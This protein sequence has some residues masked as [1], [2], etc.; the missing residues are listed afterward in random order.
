MFKMVYRLLKERGA[1]PGL[2]LA[3]LVGLSCVPGR[4]G[5]QGGAAQE[6]TPALEAQVAY[7]SG[8]EALRASHAG[9]A[10][11][12]FQK[13][14]TLDPTFA[15]PHFATADTWFPWRPDQAIA[16]TVRGWGAE[17]RTFRGQ[18][19]FV[20]NGAILLLMILAG[21]LTGAGAL[22]AFRALAYFHHPIFELARTRLPALAAGLAA[23]IVVTQPLLWGLGFY[24]TLVLALGLTWALQ[25]AGERRVT[26][27]AVAMGLAIPLALSGLG[28]MSAP[29][30]PDSSAYLLSAASE[31]PGQP[32]LGESL[33]R[34]LATG[35]GDPATHLARGLVA[36][37]VHDWPRAETEYRKGLELRGDEAHFRTNLG[38]ALHQQGRFDEAEA[39][40]VKAIEKNAK[41][42]APH[43]NLAQLSARRLQFDRVD[44]EMKIASRLDFEGVRAVTGLE[45]KDH[46]RL[47]SID[48]PAA[49]LWKATLNATGRPPLGFPKALGLFFGG[50]VVYLPWLT[51]GLFAF[52]FLVG[53]R[54]HRFLPTYACA[55]CGSVVCRKCLRRVR[56]RA[57]CVDCGE[58]ILSLNTSEFTRMLLERRLR[59]TTWFRE[60]M[61]VALQVVVPGWAAVRRGRPVTGLLL[62]SLFMVIIMPVFLR[63]GAVSPVPALPDHNSISVWLGLGLGLAFLYAVSVAVFRWLPDPDAALLEGEEES[64]S[65]RDTKPSFGRA[66]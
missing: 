65:D 33:D 29:L 55:N 20:M 15:A 47:I 53:R 52:G 66:A 9:E 61:H 11:A 36:E 48:V 18:H 30:D 10:R 21:S 42:A 39:E 46:T 34:Q 24:L 23:W 22:V 54:L 57:Y 45:Q 12:A 16:A 6:K 37:A 41:L 3:L 13:S 44:R 4:A 38:N 56:R 7:R 51:L 40:Y 63:H 64:L 31:T 59:E 35:T 14:A 49:A 43:F 25:S 8:I 50:P 58:T 60:A 19:R 32:G 26:A 1:R 62:M 17:W 28:R 27:G 2:L 5:A